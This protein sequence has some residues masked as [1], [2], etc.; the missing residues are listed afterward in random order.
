MDLGNS[1]TYSSRAANFANYSYIWE[2][3]EFSLLGSACNSCR[4][5]GSLLILRMLRNTQI[6]WHVDPL[7]GNDREI[8]NYTWTAA[9]QWLCKQRPLLGSGW[10]PIVWEP[11]QTWTQQLHS[12][13]GK[14]VSVW[15]VSKCYKQDNLVE[16]VV[17]QLDNCWG[18][19]VVS[20]CCDEVIGGATDIP[21]T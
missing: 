15:S 14:V 18:L 20:C 17:S 21:E 7:L 11:Q 5:K 4:R 8:S 6:M 12:K 3:T 19:V 2:T 16:L 13:R 10:V 9:K 1:V